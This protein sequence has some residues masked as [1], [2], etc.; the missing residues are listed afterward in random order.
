MDCQIV[1][2]LQSFVLLCF[3]FLFNVQVSYNVVAFFLQS[4]PS[5]IATMDFLSLE[6]VF[7]VTITFNFY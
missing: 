4:L 7:F 2:L 5:I 3:I 1:A 6:I